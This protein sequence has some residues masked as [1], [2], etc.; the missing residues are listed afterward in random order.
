MYVKV[1]PSQLFELVANIIR[2]TPPDQ[3]FPTIF[4]GGSTGSGK[5]SIT[6]DISRCLK[7][8]M[9]FLNI[10]GQEG[11]DVTG[12]PA[13]KE[14][15]VHY[16]APW[17]FDW[18]KDMNGESSLVAKEYLTEM[19]NKYFADIPKE[20]LPER[21]LF[22]DE[23]T[24]IMPDAFDAGMNIILEGR[25][26]ARKM[27]LRTLIITAGNIN[28]TDDDKYIVNEF[29]PAQKNRLIMVELTPTYEDWARYAKYVVHPCILD[30]VK[31]NQK[32]ISSFNLSAKNGVTLRRITTLGIM[33]KNLPFEQHHNPPPDIRLL[34]N[35]MANPKIG[36]DIVRAMRSSSNLTSD[37]ILYK[38]PTKRDLIQSCVQAG[39]IEMLSR[40][41]D[42]LELWVKQK[43]KEYQDK[44]DQFQTPV[45]NLVSYLEDVPT[46][47]SAA[48]LSRC[49]PMVL[50]NPLAERLYCD[51]SNSDKLLQVLAATPESEEA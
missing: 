31:N 10:G 34:V 38:Y 18:I 1:T 7:T 50:E 20:Q 37:D 40:P 43:A 13:D 17:W 44:K 14:G 45:A 28:V 16:A 3:Q 46:P 29:D 19:T 23:L 41:L 11:P 6:R 36:P 30:W 42:Q 8:I 24:R 25:H 27:K 39:T 48:L 26:Q 33:L 51:A 4:V 32:T 47:I 21:L 49:L 15:D 22:L 12:L 2:L 5:T 35:A 9:V